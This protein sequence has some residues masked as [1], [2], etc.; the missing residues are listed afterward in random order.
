ML[1]LDIFLQTFEVRKRIP[2]HKK[3]ISIV[4][5]WFLEVE[6]LLILK[7]KKLNDSIELEARKKL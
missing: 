3:I 4:P 6:R 2:T 5:N 1:F 7:F